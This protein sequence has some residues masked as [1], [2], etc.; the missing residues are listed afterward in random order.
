MW[1]WEND[2]GTEYVPFDASDSRF[3]EQAF[4]RQEAVVHHAT[5]PWL[6][7]LKQ[8][9]QTNKNSNSRRG[10]RRE[11][12]D[13]AATR[14][15][16]AGDPGIHKAAENGDIGLVKDYASVEPECVNFK[17]SKCDA[18]S[19]YTWRNAIENAAVALFVFNT[20]PFRFFRGNCSLHYSSCNGHIKVCQ[21]LI[22]SKADVHAQDSENTY[23]RVPL[24]HLYPRNCKCRL[25]RRHSVCF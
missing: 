25:T 23:D 3:L 21:F 16:A 8:M 2:A 11:D 9:T 15:F 1:R 14:I 13:A 7:D 5:K 10:I 17:D 19:Q 20:N 12:L 18:H 6:F 24:C 4:Q 22:A